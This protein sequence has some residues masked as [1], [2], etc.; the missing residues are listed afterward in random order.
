MADVGEAA[1]LTVTGENVKGPG[2]GLAVTIAGRP[3]GPAPSE[4]LQPLADKRRGAPALGARRAGAASAPSPLG[5]V[6]RGPVAGDRRVPRWQVALGDQVLV[7]L[8][9]EQAG[10]L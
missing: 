2:Q 7:V 4:G 6:V 3:Q 10:L 1:H 8:A 5:R 9:D